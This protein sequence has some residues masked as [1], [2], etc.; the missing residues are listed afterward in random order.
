[1]VGCDLGECFDLGLWQIGVLLLWVEWLS[2]CGKVYEVLFEVCVGE[3]FGIF[4]LIGFG[5]IELLCLIYGV[6][7]VD[8]GQVL[9]GDLL[10]CLSLCLLVDLVCQ[11]VVLIIEDCKG[12]GLLLDQLISV[13]FV[14]GNLLVLVCYGVIDWCCEE[15]LVWCQVEVLWV[16]C[17][18]IVQVVG[19]LFGGNQQKVVIGCWL[20]CDCQVLLFDELICG[21]DVGVK[22]DIYVLF[23]ELICW[24]KV[25]VV[26]FS[27]L[28]ELMLICDCIGVFLVG[29]MVD[30]FECDVWIQDV[31]LVVVFVGYKKCDVLLVML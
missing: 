31:L 5:C 14:L 3:I 22:F 12:E 7:C 10:Q 17:V 15:V 27:D 25:L 9:F 20:E 1:M 30:I 13:N 24:G 21:I 28:C 23:V 11:G 26:V 8:G 2:W 4:G 18:D 6:D 29:C 19:E 16:C